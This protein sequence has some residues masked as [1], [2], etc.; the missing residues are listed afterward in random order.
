MK[1]FL[2]TCTLT[3]VLGLGGIAAWA[4]V[5]VNPA[6]RCCVEACGA[7]VLAAPVSLDES[8]VSIL[9]GQGELR[10][11]QI[12]NPGGFAAPLAAS[13]GAVRLELAPESFSGP[14][15]AVRTLVV[16][17]PAITY[18]RGAAG[19]SNL[20]VLLSNALETA[21]SERLARDARVARG[22]EPGGAQLLV[23]DELV[24]HDATLTLAPG[25]ATL[26]LPKLRLAGIG[27][28]RGGVPPSEALA[29]VLGALARAADQAVA[30]HLSALA[31]TPPPAP[32][33]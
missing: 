1:G 30:A 5:H 6:I 24:V 28:G 18:E 11:L 4:V 14:V 29:L 16:E 26:H 7:V 32:G 3:A 2:L 19:A 31:G 10:G 27:H 15:V 21:R 13:L 17:N 12:G 23:I 20:D 22:G 25:G 9:S 8:D 33:P